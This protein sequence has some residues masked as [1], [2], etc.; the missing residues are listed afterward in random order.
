VTLRCYGEDGFANHRP[1]DFGGNL[2]GAG[3]V[4]NTGNVGK[5][6]RAMPTI[7]V[8]ERPQRMLIQ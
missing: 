6:A 4:G 8:L 7:L 5:L 3:G 1:Q 2:H